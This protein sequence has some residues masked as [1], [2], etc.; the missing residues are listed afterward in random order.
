VM[1]RYARAI[2]RSD[3]EYREAYGFSEADLA[4]D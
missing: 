2:A 3:A 4:A 1:V